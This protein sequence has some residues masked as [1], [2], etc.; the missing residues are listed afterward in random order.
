M[1]YTIT[2]AFEFRKYIGASDLYPGVLISS[3]LYVRA[4]VLDVAHVLDQPEKNTVVSA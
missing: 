3:E 4:T 2:A 1:S